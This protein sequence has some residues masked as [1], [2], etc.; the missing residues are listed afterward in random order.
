METMN[1]EEAKQKVAESKGYASFG[2]NRIH[3]AGV[4]ANSGNLN[5][6][7]TEAAELWQQSNL[8][9]I[10]KYGEKLSEQVKRIHGQERRIQGQA[11]KI[12]KQDLRIKDLEKGLK[13][14]LESFECI[15]PEVFG[16]LSDLCIAEI[17]SIKQLLK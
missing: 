9:R 16:S 7:Y 13:S 17:V 11:N 12:I 3:Y 5:A 6:L 8:E 10:K 2:V 1:F 14:A 4:I 15:G